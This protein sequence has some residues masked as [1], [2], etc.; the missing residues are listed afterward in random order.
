MKSNHQGPLRW[1]P[2]LKVWVPSFDL[3]RVSILLGWCE[4]TPRVRGWQS[5]ST[6]TDCAV[7]HAWVNLSPGSVSRGLN[8][9]LRD[10]W[11]LLTLS[12]GVRPGEA[13]A[14]STSCL[15]MS[16][17]TTK[18]MANLDMQCASE[19]ID[20]FVHLNLG[21]HCPGQHAAVAPPRQ[22]YSLQLHIGQRFRATV[23]PW[24]LICICIR[25]EATDDSGCLSI[26]IS[27]DV[28]CE[29]LWTSFELYFYY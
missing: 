22:R 11:R 15:Q 25:S 21:H 26:T 17:Q 18:C 14:M 19:E 12:V 29:L 20:T 23:N 9:R 13:M 27:Y 5:R 16:L 28:S 1:F 24:P 10:G 8:I 7:Q 2:H 6:C 3:N 4:T